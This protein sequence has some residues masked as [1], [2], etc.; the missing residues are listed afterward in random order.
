[1]DEAGPGGSQELGTQSGSPKWVPGPCVLQ[2]SPAV[3]QVASLQE[4]GLQVEEP[5]L[6]PDTPL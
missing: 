3:S 6:E 1:M 4:T 5:G 2:P